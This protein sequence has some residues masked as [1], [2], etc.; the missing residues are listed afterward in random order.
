MLDKIKFLEM[1]TSIVEIA[2]TQENTLTQDEIKSYFNGMELEA[3]HY[4][5]IYAYLAENQIKVKGFLY[6]PP[7]KETNYENEIDE[8]LYNAKIASC[9]SLSTT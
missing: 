4:D 6:T 5:H 3:E 1:L 9:F 7:K 2:K 8:N